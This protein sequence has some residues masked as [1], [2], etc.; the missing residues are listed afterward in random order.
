MTAVDPRLGRYART[1]RRFMVIAVILGVITAVLLVAQAWLLANVISDAFPRHH[2]LG[3]LRTPV[4]LLAVSSAG[5]VSWLSERTA[6]RASSAAKSD[7]RTELVERIALLGPAGLD[8]EAPGKLAVLATSGVDALDDY[9][10]RYLPQVFLAVIVPLTVL[11]V[12]VRIDWISALIIA[13]TVPLIPL[14]MALVGSATKERMDRQASVL[15]RLAGHFLD[16][17]SG[18]PT[19]KVFGRAKAQAA[20]IRDITNRYRQATMATLRVA[21]LSALILELLATISVALVAVAVGLRLLGGHLSLN[22]ALF[23]LILAPEAYLPL[24]LLGTSYHAS[25]EGMQAATEVFEVLERPLPVRGT[26]TVVPDPSTVGI[27]MTDLEVSYPKRL[28]PALHGLSASVE[29]GEVVAVAGPSGA[30]KSTLLGAFLGFAPIS[31][32]QIDIGGIDVATLDPDAWR[33]MIAWVPQRTHLF[34]RT[35]VDN[36]RLGRPDAS[37]EQVEAAVAA[38]GLAPVVAGLPYGLATRLGEGGAGL[39]TGERQ[40]VAL[41]RAFVRDAPLLLLDEPTANLDG[42]TEEGVLGRGLEAHGRTDRDHGRPTGPRCLHS[43]T[44]SSTSSLHWQ[45]THEPA[46]TG[47]CRRSRGRSAL[48]PVGRTIALTR[49]AIR[50]ILLTSLLGAGAVAA[51]IGLMGT[52]AWLISRAAQHP[53]EAALG[54]AIVGVQFFGISRGFFRYGE[55]LTG[56][57]AAFR[58]I[59]DLRVSVYEHLEQLAPSGLAE[60]RSGDLLA[61]VVQDVDSLQDLII[62]VIPPFATATL[63]GTATV[64]VMWWLLPAAGMI[65]AVAL[66]AVRHRGALADR[67]AGPPAGAPVRRASGRSG[68]VGGG[69]DRR[70]RRAAGI[71]SGQ[72]AGGAGICRCRAELTAIAARSAGTAG[73]GLALNTLL[74]GLACWGGLMV[75]VAAVHAGR[76]GGADLAVITLIPLAAFE[77]VV[78]LP[79]ATQALERAPTGRRSR[80]RRPRHPAS[81]RRPRAPGHRSPSRPTA[82]SADPVWARYPGGESCVLRAAGPLVAARPP[83]GRGRSEWGR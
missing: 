2:G 16:V 52:A 70:G 48:A 25:A 10:A 23:V 63:A 64:V 4:L 55:R 34:A 41:A 3:D 66:R 27:S 80:V 28:L 82:S 13:L 9:F 65:L 29:P 71:W 40:R 5:P 58:L 20:T 74:A 12:V 76:L 59:A 73:L 7:L 67:G 43:P 24:R 42:E 75:G 6:A 44:G 61:R 36:I 69:P 30:G 53:S 33:L 31:R 46:C 78:G 14:F 81:R 35:I 8:R 68:R 45:C 26:Q 49:P 15:H 22:T 47:R 54:V 19:L 56:H 38:A 72:G 1:T 83:C 60:F 32:G 17:V 50:G 21:F 51:S 77:L 79:V 18:L 11:V 57:D 62:R 39:S 37:D